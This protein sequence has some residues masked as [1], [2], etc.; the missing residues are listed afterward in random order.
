MRQVTRFINPRGQS[1]TFDG[2][3]YVFEKVTG[4]GYGDVNIIKSSPAGADGE[5]FGGSDIGAR[6]ITQTISIEGTTR[7]DMYAKKAALMAVLA[8]WMYQDGALG[9]FEHSYDGGKTW[10]WI[11]AM[12]KRGPQDPPRLGDFLKS[13]QLVF[14]CPSPYWR[15][16][17]YAR[18]Q[19]AY[20]GGGMRFPLR[21]GAVRFGSRGYK[22]SIWNSG[23]SPSHLEAEITGPALSPTIIKAST[24]E[25]IR[26]RDKKP[27]YEGDVLRI[28]TTPPSPRV[29]ITRI[30][31]TT[32]DAIGYI[33]LTS[34]FFMLLPGENQLQ[35]ASDDDSQATQI[36]LATLPWWG[37]R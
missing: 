25:Y 13:E 10:A 26:L 5:T 12:V 28:D 18:A 8:Q 27:L 2:G 11:P 23:D 21:L 35:Y 9:R 32:E 29:T 20:L 22:A 6:E 7:A 4:I 33:D 36:R 37:G 1:V 14:Y 24:G 16:E 17:T 3:P 34:T 15:G 30:D 19:M 31:G